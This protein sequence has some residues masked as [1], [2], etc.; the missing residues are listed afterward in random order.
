MYQNAI[1]N[2]FLDIT[3]FAD[4]RWKNADVSRSQGVC[5]VRCNC[6]KFYHCRIC[7][8]DLREVPPHPWA[9]LKMPILNR[10]KALEMHF[11][12]GHLYLKITF[13]FVKFVNTY[14]TNCTNILKDCTNI[15]NWKDCTTIYYTFYISTY[16]TINLIT[17]N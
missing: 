6:A 7:V 13:Q 4:F 16:T 8:A 3:K 17:C 5:H 14:C 1:C 2:V 15:L 11:L 10:V 9:V 12:R